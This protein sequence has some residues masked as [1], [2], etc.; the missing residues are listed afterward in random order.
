[1]EIFN[2]VYGGKLKSYITIVR[3]LQDTLGDMHDCSVW[4]ESIP[5]F[6]EKERE[7]TAKFFGDT[8]AFA[9]IE[10]GI[11]F[12]ADV[13]RMEQVRQYR[14]FA[15]VWKETERHQTWKKLTELVTMQK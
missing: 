4:L 13:A 14:A 15:R 5:G 7:R 10:K 12:F 6:L 8:S 9:R 3:S 1:M 11:L 2:P